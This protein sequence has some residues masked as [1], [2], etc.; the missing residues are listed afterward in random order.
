VAEHIIGLDLG[1]A[2]DP[3]AL[4][5]LKRT[6]IFDDAGHPVWDAR[7]HERHRTDC[8]HLSRW[9]LGTSYPS[10]VADVAKLVARPELVSDTGSQPRL[11]VD[12]TGVGRAIID[13]FLDAG[14]TA[15]V[16]PIT[17]T[18]G[19]GF[20][21]DVWCPG[22][23]G[24]WVAKGELVGTVQA[25][26][27]TGSLRIV[28]LLPLADTLKAELLGFQVRITVSANEQ[29]GAWREGAHDDLV[30]AVAIGLWLGENVHPPIYERPRVGG[31]RPHLLGG[32][33]QRNFGRGR[34]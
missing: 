3:S 31:H 21:S 27:Q 15:A 20:R 25:A 6:P 10:I 19:A 7:N 34:R 18:A 33:G 13:M 28:P 24:H 9:P 22:I 30:F 8:I 32:Q 29:F 16:V 2:R 14:L 5:V 4:A 17:C 1:Q 11:A 26:L 23:T 12:A